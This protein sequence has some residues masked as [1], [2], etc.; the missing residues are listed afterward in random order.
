MMR[1]TTRT[2]RAGRRQ[3]RGA[4][5]TGGP[6]GARSSARNVSSTRA[7]ATRST[8]IRS[9]WR[10]PNRCGCG[11]PPRCRAGGARSCTGSTGPRRETPPLWKVQGMIWRAWAP[12][13]EQSGWAEPPPPLRA[14]PAMRPSR[15]GPPWTRCKSAPTGRTASCTTTKRTCRGF[16]TSASS[17]TSAPK[18]ATRSTA[19][20][21]RTLPTLWIVGRTRTATGRREG[22]RSGGGWRKRTR[23]LCCPAGRRR[24]IPKSTPPCRRAPGSGSAPRG[25]ARCR[26]SLPS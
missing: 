18:S 15:G 19:G 2:P 25:G 24:P 7:S 9:R 17:R 22:W 26:R 16:S 23:W 21:S 8:R 20:S 6:R 13:R 4:G 10:A 5:R 1:A 11:E 12:R 3:H 14:Y